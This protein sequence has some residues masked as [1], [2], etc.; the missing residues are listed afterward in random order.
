MDADNEVIGLLMG[1]TEN[2]GLMLGFFRA[3]AGCFSMK[4]GLMPEHHAESTMSHQ[5]KQ[6]RRLALEASSGASEE[7][8]AHLELMPPMASPGCSMPLPLQKALP[9]CFGPKGTV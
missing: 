2:V 3:R 8:K 6:Q 7:S 5:R 1:F 4:L 9:N